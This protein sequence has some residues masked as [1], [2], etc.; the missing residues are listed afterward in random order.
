MIT[1]NRLLKRDLK[2]KILLEK[3]YLREWK[4]DSSNMP[5]NWSIVQQRAYIMGL[6]DLLN[7]I[8]KR[9]REEE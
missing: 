7:I 4:K 1:I 6:E 5:E 9:E 8:L 3:A 2:Y